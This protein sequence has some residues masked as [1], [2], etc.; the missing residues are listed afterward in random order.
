MVKTVNLRTK[1]E[2]RRELADKI[3]PSSFIFRR[4]VANDRPSNQIPFNDP[5]PHIRQG[6][7]LELKQ[8]P[9]QHPE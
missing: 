4:K 1:D 8:A 2:G 3:R 5:S 7:K 6:S 9:I